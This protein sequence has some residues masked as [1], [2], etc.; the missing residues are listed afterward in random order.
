MKFNEL[1]P[2]MLDVAQQFNFILRVVGIAL[3]FSVDTSGC[4]RL[5]SLMNNLKT[6]FQEKMAHET[7]SDLVWW[8]KCQHLLKPHESTGSNAETDACSLERVGSATS[9]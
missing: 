6:K 2:M 9:E 5:I 4:E 7:L 3:T 1:W 8:Y